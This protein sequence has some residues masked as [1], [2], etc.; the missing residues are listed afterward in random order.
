MLTSGRTCAACGEGHWLPLPDP[1]PASMTSDWR[2]LPQPL[3]KMACRRC[4]LVARRG[5]A[6]G[7]AL[8]AS[9]YL[10]YAHAPGG[11]F[12]RARQDR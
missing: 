3:E 4:G 8:Y 6:P 5:A 1:G 9:G 2:V 10:L 11:V 7:A 12:E